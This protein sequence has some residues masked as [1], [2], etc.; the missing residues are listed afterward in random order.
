MKQIAERDQI[1]TNIG[2]KPTQEYIDCTYGEGFIE[3][4]ETEQNP[5]PPQVNDFAEIHPDG[6]LTRMLKH[7]NDQDELR[8]AA[9]EFGKQYDELIGGRV[10]DMVALAEQTG[11]LETLKKELDDLFIEEPQAETIEKIQR[12]GVVSRLMGALRGQR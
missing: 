7:R 8:Q 3:K 9:Q 12:A 6:I 1:I 10:E 2:F 11:D 4:S 5:I